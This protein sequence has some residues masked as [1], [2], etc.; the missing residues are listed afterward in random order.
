MRARW[1]KAWP[2]MSF[3]AVYL[4]QQ[5]MLVGLTL[6]LYAVCASHGAWH[7]SADTLASIGCLT[8]ETVCREGLILQVQSVTGVWQ[9]R[10]MPTAPCPHSCH[11]QHCWIVDG[12]HSTK[13]TS[14]L[15]A[16]QALGWLELRTTNCM[17][18]WKSMR[19]EG[20]LG[21]SLSFCLTQARIEHGSLRV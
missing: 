9:M 17:P 5:G 3:F 13:H 14:M 19:G 18:L 7:A 4:I 12:I 6:P 15:T 8:G 10:C 21:R 16:V 2:L 11:A 1:G 20:L